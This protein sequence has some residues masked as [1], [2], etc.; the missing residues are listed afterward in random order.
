VVD[1][2]G[3]VF[4]APAD[5]AIGYAPQDDCVFPHLS[6]DANV[7][8]GARNDAA[9]AQA[10]TLVDAFGLGSLRRTRA[11]RLSGG[12][13][14]RVAIARALAGSPRL[15]VLDEPF[16]GIDLALKEKLID[17]LREHQRTTGTPM[18]VVTHERSEALALADEVIVMERGRV[19]GQ[20]AAGELL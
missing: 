7:A 9:R 18:I 13:K 15:V 3:A 1:A 6:V 8:Y 10:A 2:E 20:G 11:G 16:A 12:E 4:V 17:F 14:R 5:R 19:M